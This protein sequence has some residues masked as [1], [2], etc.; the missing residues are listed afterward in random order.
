MAIR[1][2]GADGLYNSEIDCSCSKNDLAPCGDGPIQKC[3]LAKELFVPDADAD[4]DIPDLID[5]QTGKIVFHD[6]DP[7]DIVCV[8]MMIEI[9]EENRD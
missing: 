1:T 4:G 8:P 6:G 7:G 9:E 3:C 5:P 2:Y